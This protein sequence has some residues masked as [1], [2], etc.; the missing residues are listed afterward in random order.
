MTDLL[1]TLFSGVALGTKYALVALGFVVIFRAT[2]VINF[3][4]GGFVLIGAYLSYN[5][6]VTW[7]MNFYLAVLLAMICGAAVGAFV[8][9]AVLRRMVGEA[10]FSVIMLTIGLL[11]VIRAIVPTIWG[12][13]NLQQGDPW[14][15]DTV[16]L[17]GVVFAVR[18]LWTLVAAAGALLAFFVFFRYSK[19][20]VAMRATAIDQEAALAQGIS[21]NRVVSVS[22]A[23][24]GVV[25]TL[26]GVALSTGAA[27]LAPS[28]EFV[29]LAAFPAM[30]LGGLDSP[31]GAVIGGLIIGIVQ[32]LTSL[33][34][35]QYAEWL[36]DGFSLVMPYVVMVIILI[37]R[38]YGLFGTEEV[39]R[40]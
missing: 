29:A 5:F 34:Q 6:S 17:G 4:Q 1:Q 23:I 26:A 11:F 3:A 30:I 24:A 25:A 13:A 31:L 9:W 8:E 19:M 37:V 2:G 32:Q 7:G 40:A 15:I 21:V 33:Y 14:G 35:P 36:G 28:I 38:P 16:E 12:F 10:S 27:Q 18:E 39:R 22:W 20:G